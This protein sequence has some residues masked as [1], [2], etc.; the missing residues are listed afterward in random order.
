MEELY[1]TSRKVEKTYK[2]TLFLCARY[3]LTSAGYCVRV[4]LPIYLEYQSY[5]I[6]CVTDNLD[7]RTKEFIDVLVNKCNFSCEALVAYIK[8]YD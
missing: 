6:L 5:I 1:C 8:L 4:T 7:K 3:K 2:D